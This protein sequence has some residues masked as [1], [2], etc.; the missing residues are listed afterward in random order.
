MSSVSS[1]H[2]IGTVWVRC[3]LK[4]QGDRLLGG[5]GL[6]G[7]RRMQVIVDDET[8]RLMAKDAAT[9]VP[10]VHRVIPLAPI[11]T[12]GVDGRVVA[13]WPLQH[14][15]FD[16][17]DA[18]AAQRFA[19]VVSRTPVSVTSSKEERGG[20]VALLTAEN[21][22]LALR[23]LTTLRDA[24]T[25]DTEVDRSFLGLLQGEGP[26][27]WEE[28]VRAR[29]SVLPRAVAS[30][31]LRSEIDGDTHA[32]AVEVLLMFACLDDCGSLVATALLC[33]NTVRALLHVPRRAR[34]GTRRDRELDEL[35]SQCEETDGHLSLT[36]ADEV[37][38]EVL[39]ARMLNR[40]GL[41]SL[42]AQH[43][44]LAELAAIPAPTKK[45]AIAA[46]RLF[47]CDF[48]E[49]LQ[50][51]A[52]RCFGLMLLAWRARARLVA[53]HAAASASVSDSSV[54]GPW[55]QPEKE[56]EEH[57]VEIRDDVAEKYVKQRDLPD[58]M[59]SEMESLNTLVDSD[60]RVLFDLAVIATDAGQVQ[61]P[62]DE[63][64][65]S[66]FIALCLHDAPFA[67]LAALALVS[68]AIRASEAEGVQY[69]F[70][71]DLRVLADVLREAVLERLEPSM[72]PSLA[73]R[74]LLCAHVV[75]IYRYLAIKSPP[76]QTVALE[77]LDTVLQHWR[78]DHELLAR[79]N[80]A[81]DNILRHAR[82]S[83]DEEAEVPIAVSAHDAAMD[84]AALSPQGTLSS[85]TTGRVNSW[86]S[87]VDSHSSV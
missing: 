54:R 13:E 23:T 41:T 17:T 16:F 59:A 87:R 61:V 80:D 69:I 25:G 19:D 4:K 45:F 77:A 53:L 22:A 39:E 57:A 67:K 84:D 32:T 78:H 70:E 5:D 74:R 11:L 79:A 36:D 27:D 48:G 6:V 24:M 52:C 2:E 10:V 58:D 71:S 38:V 1:E 30:L 68:A 15:S 34:S 55:Y 20:D 44:S 26:M 75:D 12:V 8:V 35:E 63:F 65:T 47:M 31:L 3:L 21:P 56:Q 46:L 43:A 50:R 9:G 62:W 29:E 83:I 76:Q 82:A 42:V 37:D 85:G 14:F 64:D 28:L 7:N 66:V 81:I 73:M 60:S 86:F 18:S 40:L 51:V 49:A 33:E 72:V